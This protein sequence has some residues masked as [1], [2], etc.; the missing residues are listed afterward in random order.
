MVKQILQ[1]TERTIKQFACTDFRNFY[2]MIKK[3]HFKVLIY[4]FFVCLNK[5]FKCFLCKIVNN[6]LF[7]KKLIIIEF[8]CTT[9]MLFEKGTQLQT[10]KL[11]QMPPPFTQ[12][13]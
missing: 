6:V 10:R 8:L 1:Y 2:T 4:F 11:F 9:T 13:F 5:I 7:I 12:I 3:K